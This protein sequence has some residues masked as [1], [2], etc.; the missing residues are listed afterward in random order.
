MV[1]KTF[2]YMILKFDMMKFFVGQNDTLLQVDALMH[3]KVT[4]SLINWEKYKLSNS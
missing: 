3:S 2:N 1:G 4:D